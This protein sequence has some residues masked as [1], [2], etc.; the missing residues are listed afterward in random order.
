MN[1]LKNSFASLREHGSPCECSGTDRFTGEG[2][3]NT[4]PGNITIYAVSRCDRCGREMGWPSGFYYTPS[5]R[6]LIYHTW[7]GEKFIRKEDA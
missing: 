6:G 1:S 4:P 7:D 3:S 2:E 5:K